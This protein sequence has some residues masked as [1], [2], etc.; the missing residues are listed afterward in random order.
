[1]ALFAVERQGKTLVLT[2][3]ADLREP[4]FDA[5]EAQG[6]DLLRL[7][8]SRAV[9][10]VVVDLG[11]TE[12]FGPAALALFTRLWQAVGAR[13]GR[14]ALCNA[15]ARQWELLTR[16]GLVGLWQVHPSRADAVEAVAA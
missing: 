16:T 11:R 10:N 7:V 3:Q 15:S 2:P 6:Q 8:G 9:R 13:D 4:D 12:E 1:V 14:L 5:L